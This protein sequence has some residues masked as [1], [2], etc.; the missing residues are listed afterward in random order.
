MKLDLKYRKKIGGEWGMGWSG[1][2]WT[3][4]PPPAQAKMLANTKAYR[5][6]ERRRFEDKQGNLQAGLGVGEM[7]SHRQGC[8]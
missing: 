1:R 6:G 3:P 5:Q 4:P 8:R 7:R 2:V